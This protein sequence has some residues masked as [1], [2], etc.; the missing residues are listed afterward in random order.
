MKK[1]KIIQIIFVL[2]IIFQFY[3]LGWMIYNLNTQELLLDCREMIL[4]E[5]DGE[6]IGECL[7]E[8]RHRLNTIEKFNPH[9]KIIYY[10]KGD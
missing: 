3:N 1:F 10:L 8:S 5:E 4:F 9:F 2:S 7:M 6:K